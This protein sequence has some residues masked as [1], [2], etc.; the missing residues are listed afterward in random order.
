VV[1]DDT[2]KIYG[3][4]EIM[5]EISEHLLKAGIVVSELSEKE[6]SLEEYFIGI[7]G[8]EENA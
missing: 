2:M 5:P 6:L 1:S 3:K 4:R 8:G 7:I